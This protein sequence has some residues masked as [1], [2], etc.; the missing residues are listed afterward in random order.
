MTDATIRS[1]R[2]AAGLKLKQIAEVVGI[3]VALLSR[4]ERGERTL[5]QGRTREILAAISAL[6]HYKQTIRRS[7]ATKLPP[8]ALVAKQAVERLRQGQRV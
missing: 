1:T 7:I 4:L 8:S 2:R 6:A 3:S 5:T